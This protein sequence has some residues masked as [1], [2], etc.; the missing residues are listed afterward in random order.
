MAE[1]AA[2]MMA[3]EEISPFLIV[4]PYDKASWR[5]V[6]DDDFGEVFVNKLIPY[7]DENYRTIP[8]RDHRAL[9]GLSRGGGWTI[10]YGFT[11]WGL[12]GALGAH[13]PAIFYRDYKK[14]D[15]WIAEIPNKYMPQIYI[16]IG[17]LDGERGDATNF[18]EL[19]AE[20][21]V[22]HEWHLFSGGHEETYW[23]AHV[24]DYLHWYGCFFG[25]SSEIAS[26]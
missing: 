21:G 25:C 9:G 7:I 23:Q 5:G 6:D 12:F 11:R 19:L 1:K 14:L 24:D 15:D 3:A 20:E 4:M 2:A 17:D 22:L 18:T 16:D 13:S 26:P 8:D 10:R